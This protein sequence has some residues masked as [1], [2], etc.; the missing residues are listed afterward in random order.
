MRRALQTLVEIV[1][2]MVGFVIGTALAI[3]LAWV[4]LDFVIWR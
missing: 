4:I 1:A 2:L 3:A